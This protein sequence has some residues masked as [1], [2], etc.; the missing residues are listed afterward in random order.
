MKIKIT[1]ITLLSCVLFYGCNKE[2]EMETGIPE[3][4]VVAV[5][6][7]TVLKFKDGTTYQKYFDNSL[8]TDLT[9]LTERT[10]NLGFTS[11]LD[12][13]NSYN[14]ALRALIAD[15]QYEGEG[16]DFEAYNTALVNLNERFSSILEQDALGESN[17]KYNNQLMAS[18]LN[19]DQIV[20]VGEEVM[21]FTNDQIYTAMYTSA[22]SVEN[23][24]K[25]QPELNDNT[26]GFS[27]ANENN[28]AKADDVFQAVCDGTYSC[29]CTA[30]PWEF[31]IWGYE[32]RLKTTHS[33][34]PVYKR[35]WVPGECIPKPGG[36]EKCL[37]GHWN[38]V[39]DYWVRNNTRIET[40]INGR[41][42][43]CAPSYC[44]WKSYDVTYNV[45]FYHNGIRLTTLTG[46]GSYKSWFK[47][48]GNGHGHGTISSNFSVTSSYPIPARTKSLSW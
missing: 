42:K 24:S 36:Q 11:L 27:I 16:A 19:E 14:N 2:I 48:L 9:V 41:K 34:A 23:L 20:I 15:P 28:N 31:T 47:D 3:I 1:L 37:P 38:S 35:V 7:A 12:L 33:Y 13:Q 46:H 10:R 39:V 44:N 43:R 40:S 4:E 25:P 5:N 30:W 6:G 22:S 32:G 29:N 21:K 26:R 45:S 17:L 18:F 8:N